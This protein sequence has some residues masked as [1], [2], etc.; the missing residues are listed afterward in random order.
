[1]SVTKE[2]EN[3]LHYESHYLLDKQQ[4]R[5]CGSTN[6]YTRVYFHPITSHS[7][8]LCYNCSDDYVNKKGYQLLTVPVL[9]NTKAEEEDK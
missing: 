5:E 7:R 6:V 8:W 1:M 4:C 3:D 9:S 2:S